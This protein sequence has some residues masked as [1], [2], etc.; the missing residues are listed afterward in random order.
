M[1]GKV[2]KWIEDIEELAKIAVDEPQ[3]AYC[4]YIKGLARRWAFLQRTIPNISHLFSPLEAVIRNKLL[5][6]IVGKEVCDT[7]RALIALPLRYG[8]LAIENPV[9]TADRQ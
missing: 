7:E 1:Q 9:E 8:A 5:P 3:S 4:A 2:N 6:A